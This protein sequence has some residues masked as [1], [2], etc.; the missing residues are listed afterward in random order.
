MLLFLTVRLNYC[1]SFKA[2]QVSRTAAT[3][4]EMSCVYY[5]G[6]KS[7]LSLLKQIEFLYKIWVLCMLYS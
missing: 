6:K 4:V 3:Y 1:C 2:T 7:K 5:M